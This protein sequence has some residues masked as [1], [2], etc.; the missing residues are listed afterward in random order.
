M[1]FADDILVP[2]AFC[3]AAHPPYMLSRRATS[4]VPRFPNGVLARN[5]RSQVDVKAAASLVVRRWWY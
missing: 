2:G 4:S 5:R 3:F 1:L